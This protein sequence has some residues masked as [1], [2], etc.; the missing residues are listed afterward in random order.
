MRKSASNTG[1][2][3]LQYAIVRW[4]AHELAEGTKV[5]QNYA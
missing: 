2:I 1:P 5:P 3:P 4:T